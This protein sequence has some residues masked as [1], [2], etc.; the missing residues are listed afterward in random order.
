MKSHTEVNLCIIFYHGPESKLNREP[1]PSHH[2]LMIVIAHLYPIKSGSEERGIEKKR[3][4]KRKKKGEKKA[5]GRTVS[6]ST[7]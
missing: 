4:Y 1:L 6:F 7:P 5:M 2:D 3:D